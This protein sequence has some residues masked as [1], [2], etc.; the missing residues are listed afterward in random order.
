MSTSKIA[1][2]GFAC[3]VASQLDLGDVFY[4]T[5]CYP[6]VYNSAYRKFEKKSDQEGLCC[7][8]TSEALLFAVWVL[9]GNVVPFSIG[10][11]LR[12]SDAGEDDGP[13]GPVLAELFPVLSCAP[14]QMNRYRAGKSTPQANFMQF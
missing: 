13:L 3:P 4:G 11:Y 8:S 6:C 2:A 10:V 1:R 7:D 14:C 5:C 9:L 12:C